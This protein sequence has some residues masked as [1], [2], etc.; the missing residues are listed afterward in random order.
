MRLKKLL[1]LFLILIGLASCEAGFCAKKEPKIKLTKN[2]KIEKKY[3]DSRLKIKESIEKNAIRINDAD[4]S[5]MLNNEEINISKSFIDERNIKLQKIDS[6]MKNLGHK[7]LSEEEQ[8]LLADIL[9][10]SFSQ[11]DTDIF[12]KYFKDPSLKIT[13][14]H[15]AM[16]DDAMGL[17]KLES[18]TQIY[19]LNA[20]I[21]KLEEQNILTRE[22]R[23][24]LAAQSDELQG[25]LSVIDEQCEEIA[26][27]IALEKDSVK[28]KADKNIKAEAQP[29]V[30]VTVIVP[31]NAFK[32]VKF[33]PDLKMFDIQLRNASIF[34]PKTTVAASA[35]NPEIINAALD[36]DYSFVLL[37]EKPVVWTEYVEP[38]T[39]ETAKSDETN[40]STAVEHCFEQICKFKSPLKI[41]NP[42]ITDDISELKKYKELNLNT[43]FTFTP[44][45]II[46]PDTVSK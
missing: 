42:A 40:P 20:Y 8:K 21:T 29:E 28:T 27:R 2:E 38:G 25:Q 6:A 31:Q 11:E 7:E 41:H 22:D 12:T 36:D 23:K 9:L 19:T 35:S 32:F 45:E 43:Y 1:T 34:V 30:I 46:C 18:E 14:E 16:F 10:M 39:K 4:S 5:I 24:K 33:E 15:K 44:E 26:V 37:D 13:P 3:N 17:Y